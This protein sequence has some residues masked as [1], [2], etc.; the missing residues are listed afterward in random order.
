[1]PVREA[2]KPDQAHGKKTNKQ[3]KKDEANVFAISF[4]IIHHPSSDASC[5]TNSTKI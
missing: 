3:R 1:M 5:K 4:I 2:M